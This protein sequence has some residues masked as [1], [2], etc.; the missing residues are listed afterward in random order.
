MPN[1]GEK[2]ALCLPLNASQAYGN[3]TRENQER[4][5]FAGFDSDIIQRNGRV[6]ERSTSQPS[7]KRGCLQ[8]A[9]SKQMDRHQSRIFLIHREDG[10]ITSCA[11]ALSN[12]VHRKELRPLTDS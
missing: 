5:F 4:S 6:G 9:V 8:Q 3:G 11:C 2:I 10:R 12:Y 1:D 7:R